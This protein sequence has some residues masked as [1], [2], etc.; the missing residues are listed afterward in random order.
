VPLAPPS[1]SGESCLA[2]FLSAP[3]SSVPSRLLE[4]SSLFAPSPCSSSTR[5]S[6]VADRRIPV[7]IFRCSHRIVLFSAPPP[8]VT[9]SPLTTTVFQLSR[10]SLSVKIVA[11]P[12][13]SAVR[14]RRCSSS[15]SFGEADR[16]RHAGNILFKKAG[17]HISL[18]PIDHGYCL[19]EQ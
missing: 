15:K 11:S 14:I 10:F 19:P 1:L 18:I 8:V 9:S 3:F 12:S 17:G 4:S 13:R 6:I 2:L 16:D 5:S 7:Q